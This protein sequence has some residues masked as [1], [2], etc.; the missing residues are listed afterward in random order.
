MKAVL[1]A[2]VLFPTVTRRMLI[3]W[4]G[5]GGFTPLWS[6]RILEE[7]RRAE[8]R[9]AGNPSAAEAEIALL[10]DRFPAARIA[11]EQVATA[12]VAPLPDEDD[13]HVLAAAVGGGADAIITENTRDFPRRICSRYGVDVIPPDAFLHA[14]WEREPKIV[15]DLAN[16]IAAVAHAAGSGMDAPALM[17]RARL[18]RLSRALRSG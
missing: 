2:C 15:E 10:N 5:A 7:W 1:D 6:D 11:G 18:F 12:A 3:G 13:T 17:K 9:E 14:A 8:A 16:Q 4:A